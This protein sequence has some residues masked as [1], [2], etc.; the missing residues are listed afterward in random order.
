[1]RHHRTLVAAVLASAALALAACGGDDDNGDEKTENNSPAAASASSMECLELS[2]LSPEVYDSSGSGVEKGVKPLLTEGAKGA[3]ILIGELGAVVIEYPDEQAA[4]A[5]L[6][7]AKGSKTLAKY[8]DPARISLIEKTLL[9]DYAKDP[10][11][12]RVVEGCARNPD[13]PPPT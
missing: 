12:K 4:N 3:E 10:R 7:E 6:R 9:I 11:V 5:G 1:M 2:T 13:Q 8:V